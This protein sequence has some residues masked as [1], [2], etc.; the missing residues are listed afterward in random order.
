MSEHHGSIPRVV[1][2]TVAVGRASI[3][4]DSAKIVIDELTAAHFKFVRS[5]TVNR[6]T[7]YIKLLVSHVSND[8]EADAIV[9]IGGTGVG[10]RDYTCEALD[11]FVE[12][13]IEGFGEAYRRLLRDELHFG[14]SALLARATAGVYNKC[15]IFA[16]PRRPAELRPAMQTLV[17]PILQEAVQSAAGRVL[18][19]AP[20]PPRAS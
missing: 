6:D 17:V 15:V 13:R 1:V 4:E 19:H 10:P 18:S 5:V 11:A 20:P 14:T 16:L 2:A 8:N 3:G 12:R 9:L 7:Q